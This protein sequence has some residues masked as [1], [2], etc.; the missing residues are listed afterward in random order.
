[1]KRII[2]ILTLIA[3][4]CTMTVWAHPFSDAV[5]H[6]AEAEIERGYSNQVV[7]GDID[8]KFWPDDDITRA[9]FVKL[10]AALVCKRAESEMPEIHQPDQMIHWAQ[11][12][13]LFASLYLYIPHD[14]ID[15][16]GIRPGIMETYEEFEVA[17][18]RWEMAYML[19]QVLENLLMKEFSG[20]TGTFKDS[21]EI[22]SLPE[23]ISREI[24]LCNQ[25]K[26]MTGDEKNMFNPKKT[27]TRAEAVTVINRLDDV[28]T[29]AIETAQKEQAALEEAYNK[30]IAESIKT[31]TSIP[32]NHPK[33]TIT[34][35]NGKKI[36]LELYPEYA[37]QTVANFVSLAK[38]GFYNGLTFHRIVEG[39]M[40]QGGDPNGNGTGGAE[41]TIKGEFLL[42]G[43]E[44]N[45]LRHTRGVISMARSSHPD[46]ASSQFF[47]C[48]DDASFLD[49]QYAAFGKVTK[50][51]E[52][53]D[54]FLET[55]RTANSM[56]EIS[57]PEKP[58]VIKS[59]T[60][61]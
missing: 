55:P 59:I 56:G 53:L 19:G 58:I 3:V 54:S 38:D 12:Y 18:P 13:Q 24:A 48:Y 29:E 28:I 36:E 44:K 33:V 22:Q 35:E 8:G 31:Y 20:E 26:L 14:K 50:G 60:V 21:A 52:V 7:N 46:S 41:H 23:E 11:N 45:E 5:G 15:I 47:I 43:F 34:M 49:G 57:I 6:W 40:A 25:F 37:P 9:E 30:A 16:D 27:G 42:N 39:F 17:I 1:M 32:K 4:L 61:K 51:M 10:V 2:A